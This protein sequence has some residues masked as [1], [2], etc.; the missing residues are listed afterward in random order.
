MKVMAIVKA[1]A[2]SE[3][4]KMPSEEMLTEMGK[5]NEEMAKAGVLLDGQGLHPTSNGA[6]VGFGGSGERTVTDGPF[7]ETKE[8]I[9][10]FWVMQVDSMEDAVEWIKRCPNPHNEPGE[11]EIRQIFE[12]DDFGEAYTPEAR[13][14]DER[15]AE[16]EERNKEQ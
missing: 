9:A 7:T 12:A 5:Y 16:L 15:T 14:R 1:S 6:R 8:L 10:G 13:E 3:A 11:I 2:D 4:G